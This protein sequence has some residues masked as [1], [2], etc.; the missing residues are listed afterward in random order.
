MDSVEPSVPDATATC[1][2]ASRDRSSREE[3]SSGALDHDALDIS[4]ELSLTDRIERLNAAVSAERNA[5][6][7]FEMQLMNV[8]IS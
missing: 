1:R 4:N 3:F 5:D 8:L 6:R 7:L 2:G